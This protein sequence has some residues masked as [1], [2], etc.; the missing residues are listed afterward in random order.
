MG[1][2]LRL[3]GLVL[4]IAGGVVVFLGATRLPDSLPGGTAAEIVH[5][6]DFSVDP[7]RSPYLHVV[8]GW[9]LPYASLAVSEGEADSAP[10]FFLIPL[11][12]ARSPLLA[13]MRREAAATYDADA[14]TDAAAR[15][16]EYA[17]SRLD[18]SGVPMLV[19]STDVS[20]WTEERAV[21]VETRYVEG[22]A[23]TADAALAPELLGMLNAQF[24]GIVPERLRIL[25]EGEIPPAEESLRLAML[26]GG[27]AGVLG[28]AMMVASLFTRRPRWLR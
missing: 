7:P 19:L 27:L 25:Y 23:R 8:G 18:L 20:R 16:D 17:A 22:V 9:Y 11:T 5:V 6:A 13:D 2:L 14:D 3:L 28:L 26:L 24:D 4:L 15:W 10:S 21:A 1:T 12:D